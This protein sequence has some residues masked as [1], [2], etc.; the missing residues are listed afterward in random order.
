M[1]KPDAESPGSNGSFVDDDAV[2]RATVAAALSQDPHALREPKVNNLEIAIGHEVRA[3][4]N[5]ILVWPFP[6]RCSAS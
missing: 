5:A 2:M 6:I 4:T 1:T 3:A